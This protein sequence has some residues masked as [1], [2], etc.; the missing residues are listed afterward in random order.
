MKF[1]YL[2]PLLLLFFFADAVQ[3]QTKSFKIVP[4]GV[5]GGVDEGNM[6][7]Y[8]LAANGTNN[9]ICLDAGT[10][11]DGLKKAV[12]V[13]L[14]WLSGNAFTVNFVLSIAVSVAGVSTL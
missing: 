2:L 6:S 1:K 3:A 5:L 9:Y 10:L 13:K 4:L 14:E 11:Y 12:L 8:M 7:A